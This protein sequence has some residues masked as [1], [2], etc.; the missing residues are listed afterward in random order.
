M[1]YS[2][3]ILAIMLFSFISSKV[4]LEFQKPDYEMNG[5]TI[6]SP[7][8]N[9]GSDKLIFNENNKI[10]KKDLTSFF[11]QFEN[12][13]IRFKKEGNIVYKLDIIDDKSECTEGY[14]K[15]QNANIKAFSRSFRLCCYNMFEN[16]VVGGDILPTESKLFVK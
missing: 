2:S 15:V 10:K 5:L 6:T 16:Y 11:K 12:Q 9:T 1:K 13:C 7:N 14:G 3:L 8:P 4:I